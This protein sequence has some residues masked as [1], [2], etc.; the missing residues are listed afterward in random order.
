MADMTLDV[1]AVK[2]F[3]TVADLRSFTRAAAALGS[4]QGAVSVRLK[5][6]EDRLG[7]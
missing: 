5:R 4:T 6:L 7:Q 1:E 3:V 2:A